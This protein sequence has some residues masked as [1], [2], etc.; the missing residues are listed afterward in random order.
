MTPSEVADAIGKK[1]A[2]VRVALLRMKRDG[3]VTAQAD[4]KYVASSR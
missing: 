1:A 4:G 2:T 3:D